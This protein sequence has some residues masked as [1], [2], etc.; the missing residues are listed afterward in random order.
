MEAQ[1]HAMSVYTLET[2]VTHAVHVVYLEEF[3]DI[4]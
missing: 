2:G 3:Q 1:A 4:V